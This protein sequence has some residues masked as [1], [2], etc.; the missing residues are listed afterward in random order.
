MKKQLP[1]KF[2]FYLFYKIVF[3]NSTKYFFLEQKLVFRIQH[4]VI[5]FLKTLKIILK[6]RLSKSCFSELFFKTLPKRPYSLWNSRTISPQ[7]LFLNFIV[8]KLRHQGSRGLSAV[9]IPPSAVE[10]SNLWAAPLAL[11]QLVESASTIH[12]AGSDNKAQ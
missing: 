5:L 11:R 10:N 8:K 1:N 2:L 7:V 6:N 4:Q 12:E 9:W 3:I